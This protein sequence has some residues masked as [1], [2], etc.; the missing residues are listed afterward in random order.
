VTYLEKTATPLD[1]LGRHGRRS[2]VIWH[3]GSI[4]PYSSLWIT[5]QRF[6]MLNQP[7]R[8]AFAQDFFERTAGN[9]AVATATSF[10]QSKSI[11]NYQMASEQVPMRLTRFT[12]V[13][14]ESSTAFRG[15]HIGNFSTIVRPYFGD[16]SVCPDCL[17]E[18]FHS[19]LYSFDGIRRCPAHGTKL[20]NLKSNGSIE[21][22][23]FT[24]ALRN[25]FS[26]C[27]Y[28]HK[29]LRYSEA[30]IP[31][32]HVHRDRVLGEIADWLMDI[33]SRCWLGQHGAQQVEPFDGFTN[34]LIHLKTILKF[35]DAV[36]NWVD[37][38]RKAQ[39]ELVTT[40]VMRLGSV[41]VHRGDLVDID[42]KR[43]VRH[44]TDLNIY[45]RTIFGDF[46]AI[47]RHL[48]R[49][50]LGRGGRHWLGHLSKATSSTDVNALL[51]QGGEEARRAWWLLAW[52]R[53]INEREFNQ[54]VGLHTRAMRFAIDGNIPL[55][56]ANLGSGRPTQRNHDFV[57]LWIA[58]WI[59]AVGLL[60]RWRSICAVAEEE[61]S[62][63]I[64]T[65]EN[66]LPAI[67]NEPKW[68]LGISAD[69][70]LILCLDCATPQRPKPVV[71]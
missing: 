34:R 17:A 8:G 28:L 29:V 20:E 6:L 46:K 52:S 67:H 62:L 54:K 14:K 70:E 26:E 41:K 45:G 36:P 15:S 44:Q 61:Y 58:R 57:H 25:P 4:P 18:G 42:D 55:W 50:D 1:D 63:D 3:P 65:L 59:S 11:N 39:L 2:R 12:R 51:D 27:P 43:A 53:Q 21:N 69:K 48:K 49:C 56:I 66:S 24:N 10:S 33:D 13:L 7:T 40:E 71:L 5:V 35:P 9:S 22:D 47:R 60:A 32:A 23:L 64:A 68:S 30:R 31:K 19:I 38:D 16:F 37:T